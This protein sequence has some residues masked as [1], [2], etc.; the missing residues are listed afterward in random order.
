V[1]CRRVLGLKGAKALEAWGIPGAALAK[2]PMMAFTSP[3][4][5]QMS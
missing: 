4:C 5:V 3:V 2:S 1:V